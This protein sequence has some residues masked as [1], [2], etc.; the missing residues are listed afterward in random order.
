MYKTAENVFNYLKYLV[1]PNG[2][3]KTI[4]E[5]TVAYT[6]KDIDLIIKNYK[7]M[8][9]RYK[10]NTIILK[11]EEQHLGELESILEDLQTINGDHDKYIIDWV[12]LLKKRK[13]E[14]INNISILKQN[15]ELYDY[16]KSDIPEHVLKTK[17]IISDDDEFWLCRICE[18]NRKNRS[19]ECGHV[20]CEY[21]I[22]KFNRCPN[23]K[24]N[25]HPDYIR[26]LFL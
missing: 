21:C 13:K 25:I 22:G 4:G 10:S 11:L 6:S 1:F 17:Q 15:Q 23:C 16:C 3:E 18:E 8:Q 7:Q 5:N 24:R 19:L 2:N 26:P 14:L 20:F 9:S 12:E